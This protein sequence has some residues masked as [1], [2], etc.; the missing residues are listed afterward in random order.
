MRAWKFILQ[1]TAML[2][3]IAFAAAGATWAVVW[4]GEHVMLHA[5]TLKWAFSFAAFWSL[6]FALIRVAWHIGSRFKAQARQT[7]DHGP[8]TTGARP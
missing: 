7:T 3:L 2:A 8:R 6:V 1:Y 5:A 4:T